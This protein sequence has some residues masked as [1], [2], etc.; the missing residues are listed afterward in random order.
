LLDDRDQILSRAYLFWEGGPVHGFY[1]VQ[2]GAIKLHRLN[3]KGQEQVFH[4]F[5]PTESFAEETI[6]SDAGYLPADAFATEDSADFAG[7]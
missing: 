3:R 6:L 7:S 4:V 1:I 2:A 5:R